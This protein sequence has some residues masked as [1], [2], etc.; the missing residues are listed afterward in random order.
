MIFFYQ[1]TVM[2]AESKSRRLKLVDLSLWRFRG[3]EGI[4]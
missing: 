4:G 1:Y 3:P 2:D